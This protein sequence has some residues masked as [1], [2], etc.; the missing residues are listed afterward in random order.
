MK[1]ERPGRLDES[2]R[3]SALEAL[4]DDVAPESVPLLARALDDESW[5]ARRAAGAGLVRRGGEAAV[6]A[7][8]SAMRDDPLNL[9][10]LN[11]S[12]QVLAQAG[13]D[14]LGEL[15]GFL[16]NPEVELRIGA[17]LTLGVRGDIRAVPTLVA[18]MAD[19][20]P[21]VRYH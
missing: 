7:V 21:N 14:T 8:L 1:S 5:R 19:H 17:A 4:A 12:I 10:V 15:S 20:D 6:G 18:A 11:G 13:V 3:L 2:R 9:A 16:T